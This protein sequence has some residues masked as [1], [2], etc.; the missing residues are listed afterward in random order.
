[1]G[2]WLAGV[3][4]AVTA[5]GS[6]FVALADDVVAQTRSGRVTQ[7]ELAEFQQ[8]R[9][10]SR[11]GQRQAALS[12]LEQLVVWKAL[13][14]RAVAEGLELEL[15]HELGLERELLAASR[16][17]RAIEAEAEPTDQQLM[18]YYE[19]R[20]ADFWRPRRWQLSHL[21]KK[22]SRDASAA[23]R[24]RVRRQASELRQ[25]ILDGED[26]ATLARLESDGD[27]RHRGGRAGMARLANVRPE[28]AA[29]LEELA[30][31]ELS[32]L[33]ETPEGYLL[34]FC[35]RVL[36]AEQMPFAKAKGAIQKGLRRQ[37]LE[38]RWSALDKQLLSRASPTYWVDVPA[39]TGEAPWIRYT[40]EKGVEATIT[41]AEIRAW[42]ARR[43][44]QE[45]AMPS[46][47]ALEQRLLLQLRAA[48]AGRRGLLSQPDQVAS[49]RW[50]KRRLLAEAVIERVVSD[51]L[52]P[53]T[54][55]EVASFYAEHRASFVA[56]A[57]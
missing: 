18:A 25:R 6:P 5:A 12:D 17:R 27:N 53:V 7:S 32:E 14:E 57:T 2:N 22:V 51:R 40:P 15:R 34:L 35:H 13:A 11:R 36:E 54:A 3:I 20:H 45:A 4:A 30:A 42:Q 21:F 44:R 1:M 24:E 47:S 9:P 19:A 39:D 33:V 38:A 46:R 16:L 49:E 48:E 50:L 10:P 23:E 29:I 43:P 52:E 26:F 28:V 56:P 55:A 31:G 8:H 41:A 37:A